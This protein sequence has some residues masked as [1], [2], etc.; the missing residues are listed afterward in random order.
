M[1]YDFGMPRCSKK[2]KVQGRARKTNFREGLKQ[3]PGHTTTEDSMTRLELV[4][5]LRLPP[6]QCDGK[7]GPSR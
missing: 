2:K 3:K 7:I 6:N 5:S 4:D 1:Q